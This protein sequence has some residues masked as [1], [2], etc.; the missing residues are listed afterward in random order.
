M[1]LLNFAPNS[2]KVQK[3]AYWAGQCNATWRMSVNRPRTS[4]FAPLA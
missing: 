4:C 2:A 1:I 3:I